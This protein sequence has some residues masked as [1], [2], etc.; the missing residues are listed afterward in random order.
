MVRVKVGDE[1][2]VDP[3][4]YIGRDCSSMPPD[5]EDS[6]AKDGVGE[7]PGATGL[8]EDRGMTDKRQ[9]LG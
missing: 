4:D 6:V 7:D 2:R 9:V 3:L 8:Q 5:V 1:N